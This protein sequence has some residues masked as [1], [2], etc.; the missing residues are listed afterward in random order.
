MRIITEL[1]INHTSDQHVW[2]QRARAAK[3][4]SAARRYYVW[5]DNDGAYADTRVIFVD[6]EKSNWTWDPVAEAYYWH[7]FYAHQPDLNFDSPRVLQEVLSVMRFWLDLGV[8]G[9]RLDAVPYLVEREG[10]GNE[11]LPETHAIL[12]KLRKALDDYAPGRM[13]L[14]EANQW[15]EDAQEYF[16]NGDECHMAFHFPLMPRMYMAIAQEDRFPISDIIRQTPEIPANCQWAIFLRNHDELTLEMV[17]DKERDLLWDT[18]AADRRARLNLGIRRRLAPLLEHDRNRIELMNMLLLSMPGTPVIYYGDELG[19]GDNYH[20]GDRDGVRTPMQ[21]SSDR[22]GGFSRATPENLVLPTIMN[23]VYGYEAINVEAQAGDQYS[24]LNWTR[25]MLTVRKRHQAFGRGTLRF[26]YPGNRKVLAYLRE[27][28]DETILCVCNVSRVIQAVELDLSAFSGRIPVD[29]TGGSTFP[30]VGQLPYLLTLPPFAFYWFI[31]STDAS[32]PDWHLPM[33]S[34]MDELRTLIIRGGIADVLADEPRRIIEDDALPAYLMRRR[35]FASKDE[36]IVSARLTVAEPITARQ[37]RHDPCGGRGN[38]DAPYR[39]LSFAAGDLLGRCGDRRAAAAA[40][41]GAGAAAAADR[42]PDRCLRDRRVAGCGDA[43]AGSLGG[44][45]ARGRRS[46]SGRP[47]GSP[48]LL[49]P[50]HPDIRRL[51]AEQSNSSLIIGD[52][53]IFKLVQQVFPGIHPEAEMGRY[54]TE[55]GFANTAPLLG[56]VTRYDPDGTP[57]TLVLV[58]GFLRNQGD[59]WGWT[60]DY[61]SRVLNSAGVFDPEG[62]GRRHRRCPRRV[63]QF[64]RRDRPA[65][66]R[67]ARDPGEPDRQPGFRPRKG[68]KSRC[69]AVGKRGADAA[70]RRLCRARRRQG[71]A[72]RRDQ[73]RGA[74]A[75][76]STR[77]AE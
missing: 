71:L 54:L 26:L 36:S 76:P 51:S 1:V 68:D 12:K 7:R 56:E 28:E 2:F 39:D 64:R 61:L 47:N 33:P 35:W 58:Q 16:G 30:P 23:P 49:M 42:L 27:C 10:T 37:A 24:L 40:R 69:R 77:R 20:L 72:R 32:L 3:P 55:R 14:A 53:A 44:A 4:G 60:L 25:R 67:A 22:N 52:F 18:Y 65:S 9:L 34:A 73:G 41:V 31:L 74:N 50:R 43:G 59:G 29:L 11:N 62:A 48:T 66:R 8:D 19:M 6:A 38:A 15:P 70:R 46:A 57:H 63:R 17:T 21:W 75:R 5:S 13:L 45:A